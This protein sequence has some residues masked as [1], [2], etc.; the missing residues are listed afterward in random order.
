MRSSSCSA[1][2]FLV[3]VP[4]VAW[5]SSTTS[6]PNTGGANT[7]ECWASATLSRESK[8]KNTVARGW[9]PSQ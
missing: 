9:R 3:Q 4:A 5:A 8:V 7:A 2:Q 6:S 1:V